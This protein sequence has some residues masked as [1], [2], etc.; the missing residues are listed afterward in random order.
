MG[1][2]RR[3]PR[4][5]DGHRRPSSVATTGRAVPGAIWMRGFDR[6][7]LSPL[8]P[9]AALQHRPHSG[10]LRPRGAGTTLLPASPS[11]RPAARP[12]RRPSHRRRFTRYREPG[13]VLVRLVGTACPLSSAADVVSVPCWMALPQ[14]P[15]AMACENPTI[16]GDLAAYKELAAPGEGVLA[17]RSRPTVWRRSSDRSPLGGAEG[18]RSARAAAD[19]L[20]VGDL[21]SARAW[22]P[23]ASVGGSPAAGF[24]PGGERSP[25][26]PAALSGAAPVY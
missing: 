16:L 11:R 21:S 14:S 26:P 7:F 12:C 20:G 1:P 25:E 23:S 18:G 10:S 3:R 9:S 19:P 15:S 2:S 6:S 22:S 17:S 24:R 8:R 4:W 13:A 5:F